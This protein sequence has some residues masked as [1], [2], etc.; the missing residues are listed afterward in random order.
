MY[1][2]IAYG[3]TA[4]YMQ[5]A[6]TTIAYTPT[7]DMCILPLRIVP[8]QWTCILKNADGKRQVRTQNVDML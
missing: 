6:Y 7:A 1:T 4:V 3:P 2:A 8:L 5:N